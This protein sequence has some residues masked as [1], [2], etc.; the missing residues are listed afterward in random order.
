MTTRRER[1]YI[2]RAIRKQRR[3]QAELGGFV[4]SDFMEQL[5]GA[6]V[7]ITDAF[8]TFGQAVEDVARV[9]GSYDWESLARQDLVVIQEGQP[10]KMITA[11]PSGMKKAPDVGS[12]ASSTD[13]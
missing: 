7:V 5:S 3:L 8:A 13:I 6:F 9:I 12:G 2:G 11:G 4:W 1:R 10:L